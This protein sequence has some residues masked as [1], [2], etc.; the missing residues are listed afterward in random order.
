MTVDII[1]APEVGKVY[2]VR[3]FLN[4]SKLARFQPAMIIER[5]EREADAQHFAGFYLKLKWLFD[6][7]VQDDYYE[8]YASIKAITPRWIRTE[9]DRADEE[10]RLARSKFDIMYVLKQR[11]ELGLDNVT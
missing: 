4:G 11:G 5:T 2:L 10:L 8:A 3:R 7:S 9:F 1:A 6:G